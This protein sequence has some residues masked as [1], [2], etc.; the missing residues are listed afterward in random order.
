M[1]SAISTCLTSNCY[2]TE[3]VANTNSFAFGLLVF[4]GFLLKKMFACALC[5][6][7]ACFS[8][9]V[10]ELSIDA[11]EVVFGGSESG[12]GLMSQRDGAALRVNAPSPPMQKWSES[13]TSSVDGSVRPTLCSSR[14]QAGVG[15]RSDRWRAESKHNANTLTSALCKKDTS[16]SSKNKQLTKCVNLTELHSRRTGSA[17]PEASL[18]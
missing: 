7:S 9:C 18:S 3:A 13:A 2:I 11:C 6:L 4:W 14:S 10:C 15:E 16:V 17:L 1:P 12:R 5:V 8:S